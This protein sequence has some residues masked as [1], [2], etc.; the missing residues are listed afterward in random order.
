MSAAEPPGANDQ[1]LA[2]IV[3]SS[4]DAIIAK[5]LA[6]TVFAWNK[7][8]ERMFGYSAAE[9]TGQNITRIF[10]PE[11]MA[12][13]A[14][15]LARVAAGEQVDHY[16]TERC[17]R[18][19][20][21]F[22]VSVTI[23]PIRNAGGAIVGASKIL[24]DLTQR[25]AYDRRIAQLQA[26]LAHVQRLNELGQ[27]VSSLVHEVN[28]PLTAINNYVSACRR[29]VP[30]DGAPH[31]RA[32]IEHIAA[33]TSRTRDIVQRIGGFVRRRDVDMRPEDL[34]VVIDESVALTQ[35]FL[36]DTELA[37]TVR[38]Q[39][40]GLLVLVDKIQ[41]QQ[42]LFNL[43]RNGIEAMQHQSR[44]VLGIAAALSDEEMVEISLRDSG[45]GL[46]PDIRE[47][48]FQPFVTTK[49]DGMGVGLSVCKTIVEAHAG[50]LWAED[51]PGGGT[52]FRFTVR[53]A[54]V[55]G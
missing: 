22:P 34:A 44:R 37:L 51:N 11:R 42:V 1:R 19:G 50:R 53:Y 35:T 33:Q 27:M 28:Q 23:S 47:K 9:M 26:E 31:L 30:Q 7:A 2:A 3:E 41:V 49:E 40:S 21:I 14:A 12:E 32:A 54:G 13:E 43:L 36:R 55:Q 16:E 45:R 46:L 5:D 39:P 48:L 17:R 38:L 18:D 8:A 29:L 4:D 6:G 24:R 20:T 10:P 52:V 25:V 15:L